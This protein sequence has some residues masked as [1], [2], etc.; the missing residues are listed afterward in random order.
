MPIRFFY[1]EDF[2]LKNQ[3]KT[4]AWIKES[5]R[6]EKREA[7]DIN[8]IFCSDNYL[9]KLNQEFLSHQ[10]YTDVIT[11]DY[12][13]GRIISGEIYISLDRVKENSR[14][15]NETLQNELLRVMIHGVLH[16]MGYK[17]KRGAEKAIM[18]EKEEACLSLWKKMFH[19]KR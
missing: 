4:V 11:F 15:F 17:D 1:E 9:L 12:S 10:T 16:L 19:V 6:R 5:A 18:R 13:K 8:Y 14:Q 3:K 2:K 7:G